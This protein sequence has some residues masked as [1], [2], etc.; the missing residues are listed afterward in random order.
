MFLIVF[1][2][3]IVFVI[4]YS[5]SAFFLADRAKKAEILPMA[6]VA[7]LIMMGYFILFAAILFGSFAFA[8]WLFV[9][10]GG[11]YILCFGLR[12]F[13][14]LESAIDFKKFNIV[15]LAEKF[16]KIPWPEAV[17]FLLFLIFFFD[18]F[19][20]TIVYQEGAYKAAAAGYGDIPFHMAQ[21]SYFIH[22][23]PFALEE[24]IYS[25]AKL[26]YAFL[27]NL[28]SAAFYVLSGNYILSFNLPAYIL[29]LAGFFF[30]YK[31][32]S[33]FIK[34]AFMRILAFFIFFLGMGAESLKVF[35]DPAFW[36]KNSIGGMA[37][38]L[39]HLPYPIV[40]LYNAVYPAQN[41]IWSGFMTM[42]LTHQ[43]SFFFGFAA[44]AMILSILSEA[45]KNGERKYFWFIGLLI[46]FLPLVHTH[47]F[48]AV[49]IIVFGF[50]FWNRF[51]AGD[52]FLAKNLF[53]APGIG[54]IIGLTISYFFILDFSSGISLLTYRLGWMGEPGGI[55]A[56][57]YNPA[58]GSPIWAWFSYLRENFGL[59]IPLL[60]G[61][62]I[63]FIYKKKV[64][65]QKKDSVFGL[66]FGAIF[67]FIVVNLIR[68]QPWDYDNGKIFGYFYLLGAVIIVYFFEQWK[69]KFAKIIAII[70]AFFLIS[71]GLIDT[72]SRSSL[73]K[74]PLYE[75]FGAEEQK[76]A[77]WIIQ[78]TL[79]NDVILTGTSHLNPV[80]SLAGRPV[81]VGYPGW[82]WSHGIKYGERE[83]DVMEIYRGA[84]GAKE[85]LKKYNIKYIYVGLSE[86]SI[87]NF[88]ENFFTENFSA[89]FQ[90][91]EIKIYKI[92]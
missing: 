12:N 2:L 40:Y 5:I 20:K 87:A 29:L 19:S 41:N 11:I 7:G 37:N 13:K 14:R 57:Q 1:A 32:I 83:K 63:Y 48:I 9:A 31:F 44:G 84:V 21:V 73:A 66:I 39:L 90:E 82:L 64:F 75:I 26:V 89:V 67:I 3:I 23:T 47:T 36:E 76:A 52:D 85:L 49:L 68:F 46:G 72:L 53:N 45:L 58:G 55:G 69:F 43:R 78:N 61:A 24:P 30:I 88:N 25:G 54:A 56:I 18:I 16:K 4:G 10:L 81:L 65:W 22:N 15:F 80:N 71:V 38:Y 42:F 59:F 6:F 92:N 33:V 35:Q 60:I 8:V 17:F 28:L 34:T 70:L 51:F 86:R 62:I 77:D 79:S 27:I 74:P 91:G 50:W